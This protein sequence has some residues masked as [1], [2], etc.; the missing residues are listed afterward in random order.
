MGGI[1][2][3]DKR[4]CDL[5]PRKASGDG[6][7]AH[8]R[9]TGDTQEADA[10]GLQLLGA[11]TRGPRERPQPPGDKQRSPQVLLTPSY[12]QKR[13]PECSLKVTGA[14]VH[15]R[16]SGDVSIRLALSGGFSPN[17]KKG[18]GVRKGRADRKGFRQTNTGPGSQT[19]RHAVTTLVTKRDLLENSFPGGILSL[20]P[21]NAPEQF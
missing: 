10:W 2:E 4:G 8:S 15:L 12:L 3:S 11:F 7:R 17:P 19:K 14:F 21:W 5:S 20:G 6:R 16:L 13:L 9:E 1:H 18:R